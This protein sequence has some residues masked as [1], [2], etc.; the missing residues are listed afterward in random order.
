[1]ILPS[2]AR[3]RQS[4]PKSAKFLSSSFLIRSCTACTVHA[5]RMWGAGGHT[6]RHTGLPVNACHIKIIDVFTV[7]YIQYGHTLTIW[8]FFGGWPDAPARL[9]GEAHISHNSHNIA[10]HPA[11]ES[12]VGSNSLPLPFSVTPANVVSVSDTIKGM[13][14]SVSTKNAIDESRRFDT[15]RET[16]PWLAMQQVRKCRRSFDRLRHNFH[17]LGFCSHN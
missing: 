16:R 13:V 2:S 14:A 17:S 1:M 7:S 10:F 12:S 5:G 8:W 3:S 15:Q 6:Q 11:E 9:V 4:S